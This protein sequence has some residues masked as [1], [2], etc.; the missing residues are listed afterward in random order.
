MNYLYEAIH[1]TRLYIKQCSH[2]GLKYFGK[3]SRKNIELYK[4][5]GLRWSRH[6]K[7]H[8]AKSIHLWNS[9]WYYDTSITKFALKFSRINK[10][11]ESDLWANMKYEDGLAGGKM[12]QTSINKRIEKVTSLEWKSTVGAFVYEK[13]KRNISKTRNSPEW[14]ETV[15][16]EAAKKCSDTKNSKEWQDTIGAH[17]AEEATRRQSD[18]VWKETKGKQK[19]ENYKKTISD[20]EWKETIGIEMQRKQSERAKNRTKHKCKYCGFECS[21]SNYT[22]WHGKNCK[23]YNP[24]SM[25]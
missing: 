16:K 3:T 24:Q 22:R 4:G 11:V 15:G 6:L 2:C 23:S 18:P 25:L 1:P 8:Q 20:V 12:S 9:D 21:G 17:V 19:T 10:I 7:R 14:K 5:S 13:T